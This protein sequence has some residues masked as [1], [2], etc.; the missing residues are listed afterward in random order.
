ME[1]RLFERLGASK[2]DDIENVGEI[3]TFPTPVIGIEVPLATCTDLTGEEIR[4]VSVEE[5]LVIWS[6]APESI[7]QV[8]EA[9]ETH[10]KL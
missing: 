2:T 1:R 3:E 10:V 9:V 8:L 4:E 5:S 6:V 7:I